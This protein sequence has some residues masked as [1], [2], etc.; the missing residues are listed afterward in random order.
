MFLGSCHK[1]RTYGRNTNAVLET[2]LQ[3]CTYTTVTVHAAADHL[4]QSRKPKPVF[5]KWWNQNQC[6]TY[7]QHTISS[8]CSFLGR[9]MKIPVCN[10]R[11]VTYLSLKAITA[12]NLTSLMQSCPYLH[13]DTHAERS[14][15]AFP[16]CMSGFI[17][18]KGLQLAQM[19]LP[20]AYSL[21]TLAL[22][23][24]LTPARTPKCEIPIYAQ[25]LNNALSKRHKILLWLGPTWN[26]I[27]FF[28]LFSF[29][30]SLAV[31]GCWGLNQA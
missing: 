31:T 13:V 27:D 19:L 29:L 16:I 3:K 25:S 14:D 1:V 6:L 12:L 5:N 23:W 10:Y 20:L 7:D 21:K 17:E 22:S 11:S 9:V 2:L 30:F 15:A 8:L 4:L 24:G 18:W 28:S 26:R